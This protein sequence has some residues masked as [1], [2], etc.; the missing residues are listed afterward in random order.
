M[1]FRMDG[2]KRYLRS[3]FGLVVL[4]AASGANCQKF[5]KSPAAAPAMPV[6]FYGQPTLEQIVRVVNSN[7]QR[8]QQLQS[9]SGT[10]SVAGLPALQANLALE[11]PRRFRLQAG[12]GLTGST[13]LDLG[14]N[15]ELFWFWAKRNEPEAVYYA[16][17]DEFRGGIADQIMPLPPQW[18][19]STLGLIT[20][21][22]TSQVSGPF[23]RQ[24][25]QLE[26]H[27]VESGHS[28]PLRR[29]LVLHDQYGYIMQQHV[30][31]ANGQVLAS[32][33]ASDF[34]YDAPTGAVLPR[35]IE[36]QL[37]PAELAFTLDIQGYVINQLYAD[38]AQL[39]SMPRLNGYQYVDLMHMTATP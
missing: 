28:G 19:I 23:V 13:E 3:L 16:R 20:L 32:T 33:S 31:H 24:P 9:T 4:F 11:Q 17:H 18:I 38:P 21:D 5:V 36:I 29:I 14:S 34:Q 26:I 7:A 39:W 27:V 10:L 22:P 1:A 35:K 25:G 12:F 15:D 8:V 37:P 30:Y 2:S 6:A